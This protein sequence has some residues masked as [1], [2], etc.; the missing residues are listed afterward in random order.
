MLLN[1]KNCKNK[2]YAYTYQDWQPLMELIPLM[3]NKSNWDK[4]FE[5]DKVDFAKY[6]NNVPR[7]LVSQFLEIVYSIPIMIV[8]DWSSWE[9]GRNIVNDDKFDYD[10]IDLVK[11]CKLITAIVR[12]DRFCEDALECELE[13]G[14]ILKILKSIEKEISN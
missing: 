4:L 3:E 7:A 10:T 9:E 14:L 12:Y 6:P 8:F 2:I 5:E 1:E 11:K 13:S